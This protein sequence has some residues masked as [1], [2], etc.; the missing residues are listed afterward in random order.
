LATSS[1]TQEKK[2]IQE[3]AVNEEKLLNNECLIAVL[4]TIYSNEQEPMQMRDEIMEKRG[5]DSEEAH[6]YQKI[7]E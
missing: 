1:C 4:D 7:Y 6:E 2:R 5:I 3:P